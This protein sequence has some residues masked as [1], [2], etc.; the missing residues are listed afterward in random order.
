MVMS[1]VFWSGT[2]TSLIG[3]TLAMGAQCY[4]SK[5]SQVEF[6]CI[7]IIRNTTA[8]EELDIQ[9]QRPQNPITSQNGL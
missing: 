2:I 7:K 9:Q 5:C 8:E 6:C 1:E 4:K 3:F